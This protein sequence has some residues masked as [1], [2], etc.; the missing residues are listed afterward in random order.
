MTCSP[1]EMMAVV[2]ARELRNGEVVFVGIGLPNLACNLA[3]ATHAPNL[4]LI[5]ESG[6][7]GAVPERLPVSIGDPSLVTGSLMVCGMADVFQS[8]LQNG[9]IE[10]G[11]LGG[12]QIDR[13]GNINTTVI[14]DYDTPKVRLP[15]AGG[16]PEIARSAG[17]V[18]VLL[19]HSPRSFVDEVDFITSVGREL[20]GANG[21]PGSA[22]I[23]DLGILRP[24][25]DDGELELVALH[26]GVELDEVREATG[27]DLRVREPLE[28]TEP[29]T[30]RE[31]T[32]LRALRVSADED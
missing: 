5:Y 28:V 12:A 3:R 26:P 17:R 7:V 13:F 18:I 2:A 29:V 16:A 32:E 15:G 23:T 20:D 31:L 9:R 30:E 11:F 24:S 27:W 21:G 6:A 19:R 10:V 4:V 25:P 1:A 14:G 22:V 8:L